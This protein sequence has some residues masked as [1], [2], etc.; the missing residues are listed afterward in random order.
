MRATCPVCDQ[1]ATVSTTQV[2]T[3]HESSG[4][5]CSGTG[6]PPGKLVADTLRPRPTAAQERNLLRASRKALAPKP[7]VRPRPVEP[8]APPRQRRNKVQAREIKAPVPRPAVP[9]RSTTKPGGVGKAKSFESRRKA[10]IESQ[11][12][13]EAD[14]V[15]RKKA[16][17]DR[18]IVPRRK[19]TPD[20]KK[21]RWVQSIVGG[22]SPGLGKR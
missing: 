9:R 21:K 22:G 14:A 17:L 3:A 11:R 12:I 2:M 6:G 8:T 20:P 13:Y 1:T 18:G 4:G 7:R 10:S 16:N 5:R 19:S 15:A